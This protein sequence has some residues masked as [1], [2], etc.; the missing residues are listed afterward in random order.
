M[1]IDA[2]PG[3]FAVSCTVDPPLAVMLQDH[4]VPGLR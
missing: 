4:P 2:D 3:V 1:S